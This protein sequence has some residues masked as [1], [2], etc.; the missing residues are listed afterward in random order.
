[1]AKCSEFF[2]DF[3]N[4]QNHKDDVKL[5]KCSVKIEKLSTEHLIRL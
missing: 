5:R 4:V 3:V 2:K 1:M